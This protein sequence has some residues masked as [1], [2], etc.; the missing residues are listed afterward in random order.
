MDHNITVMFFLLLW[1]L[2]VA[3]LLYVAGFKKLNSGKD[4]ETRRLYFAAVVLSG[5]GLIFVLVTG[6]YVFTSVEGASGGNPNPGE[7]IFD[8]AKTII[9]PIVTLV[10]GYYFG[11]EKNSGT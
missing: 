4:F 9:P 3:G 5:L 8:A 1:F 2:L 6:L 11:Q 10:L 7:K